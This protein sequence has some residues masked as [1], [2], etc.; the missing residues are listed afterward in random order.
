MDAEPSRGANKPT[1]SGAK[2]LTGA[3][4]TSRS[5][6]SLT[7]PL[8]IAKPPIRRSGTGNCRQH[9]NAFE[10]RA[11]PLG[12]LR[13]TATLR[14]I[15][16]MTTLSRESPGSTPREPFSSPYRSRRQTAARLAPERF[17][18]PQ[19]RLVG[20]LLPIATFF[21]SWW[22][23]GRLPGLNI[24]V[25]DILMLICAGA[26]LTSRGLNAAMFGRVSAAWVSGVMLLIGGMLIGSLVHGDF[27]RWP[28]V[29]GQYAFA[30]LLV[31][32]MLTSCPRDLLERCAITYVLGVAAS[33][34]IGLIL[35]GTLE[36]AMIA[37]YVNKDVVTGNGRLGAMTGEPNSNGAVCTFALIFLLHATMTGR[38]KG[39]AAGALA[40]I[41]L[42]GLVA[43]ASFTG[44]AA[45]MLATGL[46]LAF[47]RLRT[48][49]AVALPV[50]LIVVAYTSAGGPVP[51][52]FEKRVGEAIMTGDPTR[53]GT[54]MGRTV[55]IK[56]AWQMADDNLLIG[57]GSD[58]YRRS[59]VYGMPVH[60]LYLLV[61]NEGGVLSFMGLC[62]IF[63]AM[64]VKAVLVMM[65][66]RLDGICCVA[67]LAVF[68]IYTM[69]LPHMFG[70]MWNGPPLLLFALADATLLVRARRASADHMYPVRR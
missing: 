70:R 43:S 46:I 55:L 15:A 40:L 28:V 39:V 64:L 20:L 24:T 35:V 21:L 67:A 66:N 11:S 4:A 44:A 52:V 7:D 10:Q 63:A 34:V 48:A 42:A 49:L 69:S 31:P 54:F 33:Q 19:E 51:E 47:S 1:S 29:G 38:L 37:E 14:M 50:V 53:A 62:L 41:L 5:G 45:A 3:S 32:M 36:P 13:S 30:L 8:R 26:L 9:A 22:Q 59:S 17:A 23:V 68:F 2:G 56:E 58:G 57:L 18:S 6:E 60:Q 61:L 65:K 12:S 25:C 16:P 27:L